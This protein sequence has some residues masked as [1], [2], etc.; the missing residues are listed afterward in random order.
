[1]AAYHGETKQAKAQKTSAK[2][3]AAKACW[4]RQMERGEA[5]EA[6]AAALSVSGD[7]V[8]AIPLMFPAY[9]RKCYG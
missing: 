6:E 2:T 4:R 1:M 7:T 8:A 9:L 5:G 3:S